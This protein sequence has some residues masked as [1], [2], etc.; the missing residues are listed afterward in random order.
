MNTSN[1]SK[2]DIFHVDCYG[3]NINYTEEIPVA[4]ERD[5]TGMHLDILDTVNQFKSTIDF[6]KD[7]IT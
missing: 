4:V 1:E 6:L 2:R 3:K 5:I 7:E